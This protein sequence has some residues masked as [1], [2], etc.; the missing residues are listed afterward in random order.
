MKQHP[1]LIK[2]L[3]VFFMFVVGI[4][5][6][7][8][9]TV[10]SSDSLTCATP[11]TWL[12]AIKNGNNPI[13]AGITID[14]FFPTA[15]NPIG[16]SFLFYGTPYTQCLIGPNGNIC[17]DATL[18]GSY[19]PWPITAPLLGNPNVLNC[20]CGPWTDIDISVAPPSSGIITYSTDGV[21]PNRRYSI[22]YCATHMFDCT[23][24][25]TTTQVIMYE[26]SNIIEIHLTH[27]DICTTWNP[28]APPGTGGRAIIGVQNALGTDAVTAPGRDWTPVWSATNEAWR[29]TP[30]AGG[31]TYT[32]ASIPY[33]PI[34]L[35]SSPVH[36]YNVNTGAYLGA[37]NFISVCPTVT[38][39]YKAGALG[40]ADTSFGYYTVTPPTLTMGGIDQ[41]NPTTC[42]ICDGKLILH[43][44]P[45][46][47]TF[48]ITYD[49]FGTPQPAIAATSNAMG[50][51]TMG[52]LCDGT[53]GNVVVHYGGC[54]TT[55]AG[56]FVIISPTPPP[57]NIV[58]SVNPTKCGYCDGSIKLKS[59]IP[60][61]LDSVY[62]NFNG[63]PGITI[64]TT[65]LPDSSIILF[66]LCAG[67]YSS[68][69]VRTG[70]CL[71]DV[72]G[73]A[74]LNAP[75]INIGFDTTVHYGC[76]QDT[77]FFINSSTPASELQYVWSF[78]DGTS[79]TA[80]NPK[81]A[82]P[83][84]TYT[85]TLTITNGACTRT[86]SM[87]V[88]LIH[89]LD[90]VFS[91]SPVLLCQ[92]GPVTFT[93][94]S[95]GTS[96]T[97]KWYFGNGATDVVSDPVY[98]YTNTGIYNAML[99]ATDFIGCHDTAIVPIEV[100]SIAAIK[101]DVTDTIFC[102]GSYVTF[103]GKY[104]GIG[105]IGVTWLFSPG[106]SI[107][108]VNP[109]IRA[110]DPGTYT[111]TATPHFRLCRDSSVSR[112]IT[113]LPQ[114]HI[115]LGPDTSICAGSAALI[116]RDVS[117]SSNPG[118]RWRWNSGA[119]GS[120][121]TVVAPDKYWVTVSINSCIV[122][123]TID[124][125]SDC[126]IHIPNVF[127]PNDDGI[128]DYFF[129]RTL[130]SRGLTQFH[131]VIYNRWGEEVFESRSLDGAGWNGGYKGVLQPEGVYVYVIDAV[132]KD[133]QKEH[134]QGNVTLLR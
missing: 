133:G 102:G 91:A 62:Y 12:T 121:I 131:M 66:G 112:V 36:W 49:F 106:D 99:V 113:V 3:L 13:D 31:T 90:A 19:T 92:R 37:A 40:C 33:T 58:S 9:V 96:N 55:P 68:F 35:A 27:K 86:S 60:L 20:I 22:T 18:A 2:A 29:F 21:A 76:V 103:T 83:Q 117:N 34:P 50:D 5:A 8:Q 59:V 120:S 1:N 38:T 98:T 41:V 116:I 39:T 127:S 47:E 132:F 46:S 95:V 134:H 94:T 118:A 63:S 77:V 28:S 78:G 122:S 16:F 110:F 125:E 89:P 26:T 44:L 74:F 69:K 115:D 25:Y 119:T 72:T 64:P 30:A 45:P 80:R 108:N 56:P 97:Y 71:Y 73:V 129:P 123:D 87:V 85:V 42:L 81:H 51:V 7:S 70:N 61:S 24:Q 100:D 93:N 114:P 105:N 107:L 14:D 17:F 88:P 126:Y 15:P 57:A 128:N 104:T 67:S 101:V 52:G 130:L 54:T 11:C 79:D 124:V 4:N 23:S 48:S 53:Y 82:F 109:V 111:I 65:A 75:P 6:R 32:V 43:G 84:G 10:T